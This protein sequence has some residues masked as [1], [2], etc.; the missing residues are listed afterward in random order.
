MAPSTGT[1][2]FQ[3]L[4]RLLSRDGRVIGYPVGTL[5]TKSRPLGIG[6]FAVMQQIT[7]LYRILFCRCHN[8]HNIIH[9]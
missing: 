8:I 2:V 7:V 1:T 5:M 6:N 9:M 4:K 3:H